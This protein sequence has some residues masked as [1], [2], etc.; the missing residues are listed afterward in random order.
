MVWALFLD[1]KNVQKA[2]GNDKVLVSY[3][4]ECA[5]ASVDASEID[6]FAHT[7]IVYPT[8]S[9]PRKRKNVILLAAT[10]GGRVFCFIHE[11]IL[12]IVRVVR[13]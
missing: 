6:L 13:N 12:P 7:D 4:G 1:E 9:I 2:E 5:N 10:S 11:T 3:E 8:R